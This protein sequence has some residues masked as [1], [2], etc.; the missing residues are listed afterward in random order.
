[1]SSNPLPDSDSEDIIK[2]K[3]LNNDFF[4]NV[5]D[6]DSN[7]YKQKFSKIKEMLSFT[8]ENRGIKESHIND[9]YQHYKLNKN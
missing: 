2:E 4:G 1:M 7:L 3:P 9:L 8:V 5:L 6:K